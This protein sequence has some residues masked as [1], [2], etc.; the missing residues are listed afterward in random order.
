MTAVKVIFTT[1]VIEFNKP[2]KHFC[3]AYGEHENTVCLNL[4]HSSILL[5]VNTVQK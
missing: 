5:P 2:H 4:F 1:I 3:G